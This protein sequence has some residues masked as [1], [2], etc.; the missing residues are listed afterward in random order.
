MSWSIGTAD[1]S[2]ESALSVNEQI[3]PV[4]AVRKLQFATQ[5]EFISSVAPSSVHA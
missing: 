5:C 1:Y 3:Q 2:G 4:P